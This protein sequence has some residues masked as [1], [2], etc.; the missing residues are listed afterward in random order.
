MRPGSFT[1]GMRLRYLLYVLGIIQYQDQPDIC[2]DICH[3][4][5]ILF[6]VMLS[7]YK[8]DERLTRSDNTCL[9][10]VHIHVYIHGNEC[11]VKYLGTLKL[12]AEVQPVSP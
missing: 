10:Y 12:D 6:L 7:C 9:D 8:H 1:D 3:A 5:C 4:L 2:T 11:I